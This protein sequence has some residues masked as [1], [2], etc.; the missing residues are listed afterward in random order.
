MDIYPLET[1][2]NAMKVMKD[3]LLITK[4]MK[5]FTSHQYAHIFQKIGLVLPTACVYH[6]IGGDMNED[7]NIPQNNPGLGPCI[8]IKN[9]ASYFF[10]DG[11]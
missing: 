5:T 4:L 11:P 1:K 6:F 3:K 7:V 2:K 10:M 8:E 9:Y